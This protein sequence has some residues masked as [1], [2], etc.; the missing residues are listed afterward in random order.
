MG[1]TLFDFER[2]PTEVLQ[3]HSCALRV[4]PPSCEDA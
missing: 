1:V 4:L 2:W 3:F